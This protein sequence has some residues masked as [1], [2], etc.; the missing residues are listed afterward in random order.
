MPLSR[1]SG[2]FRPADF[3]LLQRIFDQLCEER[4]LALNDKGQREELASAVV[5][6][7]KQGIVDEAVLLRAMAERRKS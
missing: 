2:M 7:F 5:L 4:G 1:Y 6:A 3:G